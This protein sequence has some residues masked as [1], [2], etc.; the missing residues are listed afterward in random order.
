MNIAQIAIWCLT[1]TCMLSCA[2]DRTVT[3]K[4]DMEARLVTISYVSKP[5][6]TFEIDGFEPKGIPEEELRQR[7]EEHRQ[8]HPHATYEVYAEVK[9]VKEQEES[10]IAAIRAAGVELKHYWAPVS[11]DVEARW[12]ERYHKDGTGHIDVLFRSSN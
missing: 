10:I 7:V 6:R 8:M 5:F 9:C 4:P 3:N 1:A 2:S 11:F 12:P